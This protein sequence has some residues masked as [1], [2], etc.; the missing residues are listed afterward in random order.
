MNTCI[1]HTKNIWSIIKQKG[2]V[3]Q[4]GH[5]LFITKEQAAQSGKA[6]KGPGPFFC[7]FWN[8]AGFQSS[9]NIEG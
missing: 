8:I 5:L 9:F 7:F 2:D 6:E 3:S 4:G 1:Y